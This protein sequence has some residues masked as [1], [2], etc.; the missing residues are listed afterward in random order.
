MHIHIFFSFFRSDN[1][2]KKV[3]IDNSN[4]KKNRSSTASSHKLED[5]TEKQLE[6]QLLDS[7]SPETEIKQPKKKVTTT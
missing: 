7:S 4:S 6:M 2:G 5:E 3:R 1:N